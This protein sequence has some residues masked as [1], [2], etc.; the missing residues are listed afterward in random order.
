VFFQRNERDW[1]LGAAAEQRSPEYVD[2]AFEPGQI[3]TL[4]VRQ[5]AASTRVGE[6]HWLNA[7]FLRTTDTSGVF[8]TATL[9]WTFALSSASTLTANFSRF[10]GTQPASKVFSLTLSLPLG[11]RD[12]ATAT[13]ERRSGAAS[14]DVLLDVSRNLLETDSFGY[15]LVAGQQSAARRAEVGGFLQTGV[16]QFGLEFADAFNTRSTRAYARGGVAAAGGEWRISRYLDQSFAIVKVADFPDVRVFGNGQ[17]VGKTDASGTAVIPRLSG[18]LPSTISFEGEDIPLEGTFGDNAK[19]VK[20]AS[21][22]GALVD[23][24]VTRRISATLTLTQADKKPVPA[25]ASVRI[26]E[27]Q[28]EFPVARQGRVYVS[29]LA[30]D[31]PNALHVRMGERECRASVDLPSGFASGAS[32]G[33]FTCE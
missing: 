29:G 21:R 30:R 18:F 23:M 25:G 27:A 3:R 13:V 32:L 4:A 2:I 22:M 5:F 10:W 11:E 1:S 20:I 6:R 19:R 16:G 24:G 31:K 7:L 14:T 12:F 28:E 26:G 17:P 33:S 8:N 9:G 15:H